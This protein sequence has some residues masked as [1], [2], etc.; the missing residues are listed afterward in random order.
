MHPTGNANLQ[1]LLGALERANML[2]QFFTTFAWRRRWLDPSKFPSAIENALRRRYFGEIPD[3]RITAFPFRELVRMAANTLGRRALVEHEV[4][5]A[6]VDRV[7]MDLDRRVARLIEFNKVKADAVYAYEDGA[8]ETFRAAGSR[9]IKRIYELPIG[10]WRAGRRILREEAEL[11]PEWAVTLDALWDSDAKHERKDEEIRVADHVV[12]PSA[13]VRD[14]LKEHP[15][16][17]ASVDIVPYGAPLSVPAA[18]P[19]RRRAPLLRLLYVGHLAQRKGIS[20][21]FDAM[22]QVHGIASLTL[23]GKRIM[24]CPALETELERHD[25]RGFLPRHEVL[26]IMSEHDVLVFPS[27]FE[28]FALVILEAM[29]QGLPAITT[30]NSGAARV[31]EHKRDGYIVP[32][33]DPEAIAQRIRELAADRD[34]LEAMSA[35]AIEKAW[36]M[37]WASQ[38]EEL[39]R[40]I[41]RRIG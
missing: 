4:G 39:V 20:Y 12:V 23:I 31:I 7:N 8:L 13:F 22:R 21:L 2:E 18:R 24:S 9:G 29:A 11:K 10:Y 40:T 25:W 27:L 3:N 33:R 6:S 5:W 37:S 36:V 16:F 30:P 15:G 32:I 26:R 1:A 38:Q 35:A 41:R 34:K 19:G 14:T 28:G 17:Q